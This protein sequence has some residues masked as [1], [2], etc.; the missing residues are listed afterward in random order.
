MSSATTWFLEAKKRKAEE[1][2]A[3]FFIKD[4]GAISLLWLTEYVF[5]CF[6]ATWFLLNAKPHC[7]LK[8]KLKVINSIKNF[9]ILVY[10]KENSIGNH[11]P[12]RCLT[13]T[14]QH[15]NSNVGSQ[16]PGWRRRDMSGHRPQHLWFHGLGWFVRVRFRLLVQWGWPYPE[17][18][19]NASGQA[20]VYSSVGVRSDPAAC[21]LRGM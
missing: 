7:A 12:Q 6:P 21:A 20:P 17:G 1:T 5:H 9:A 8:H 14:L 4:W 2:I 15:W 18:Q 13:I 10:Y 3:I 16:R 11:K 19:G